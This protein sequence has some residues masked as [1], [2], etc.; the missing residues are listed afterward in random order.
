MMLALDAL[1]RGF[2][3]PGWTSPLRRA[4][5]TLMRGFAPGRR[6]L[7]RQALGTTGQR[8]ARF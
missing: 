2:P 3:V 7:M 6:W 5:F 4:G 1:A 8:S